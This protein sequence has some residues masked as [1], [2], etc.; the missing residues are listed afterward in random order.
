MAVSRRTDE[1]IRR[2][3]KRRKVCSCGLFQKG[4][5]LAQDG[6][7]QNER[8]LDAAFPQ[9]ERRID[10]ECTIANAVGTN[11]QASGKRIAVEQ[12]RQGARSE[13]R[14]VRC[15]RDAGYFRA[16]RSGQVE[17]VS[18]M[19]RCNVARAFE[20]RYALLI[21]SGMTQFGQSSSGNHGTAG[22][23]SQ[24]SHRTTSAS[25]SPAA[26]ALIW[27]RQRSRER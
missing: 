1:V 12:Y 9:T 17:G 18:G 20:S 7:A 5:V 19:V 27:A 16:R 8:G 22:V 21:M 14:L 10:A 3:C 2:H 25:G 26:N 15:S 11:K 24:S 13:G 23:W 4:R 6:V